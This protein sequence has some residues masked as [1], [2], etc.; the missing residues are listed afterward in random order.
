MSI[1]KRYKVFR[2]PTSLITS[3]VIG[4]SVKTSLGKTE[5]FCRTKD[6]KLCRVI[7]RKVFLSLFD[8]KKVVLMYREVVLD[9]SILDLDS[10]LPQ[11]AIDEVVA[12]IL[13]LD[14]QEESTQSVSS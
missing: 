12:L 7:V 11:S 4:L 8:I 10:W 1:L 9:E 2:P 5:L 3:F 13:H 14:S 6:F